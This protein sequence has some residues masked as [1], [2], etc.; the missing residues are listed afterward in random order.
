MEEPRAVGVQNGLLP[1]LRIPPAVTFISTLFLSHTHFAPSGMYVFTPW[2][3]RHV[4]S[5]LGLAVSHQNGEQLAEEL[6]IN[7]S[8]Q[9][10]NAE[11]HRQ[12]S[13]LLQNTLQAS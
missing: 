10:R 12:A 3:W 4:G 6:K 13:K 2:T 11:T 9:A 5:F 7:C 1:F 8:F